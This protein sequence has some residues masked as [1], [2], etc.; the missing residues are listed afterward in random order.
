M[1]IKKVKISV[2][3]TF[4]RA[5]YETY[6]RRMID[7]FLKNWPKDVDLYVYGEDCDIVER[8]DNLKI[9]DLHQASPELVAF[10]NKWKNVPKAVGKEAIPPVIPGIK[11]QPGLGFKW[12]AVRFSHKV[13]SIFHCAK[14]CDSDILLWMDADSVCHSPINL[15]EIL[16]FCPQNIDL[17]FLGR[18]GK[19]TECGLYYMNLKSPSVQTF[20]QRFQHFY[21]EAEEGIFKLSEWHDSFVFDAVRKSMQLRELNWSAGLI[22]GEGHP[23]INS[24]WGKY[25]DHLKG[26]RKLIGKSKPG[27]LRVKRQESYWR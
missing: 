13:Y 5:G 20:L 24:A 23:L 14:V 15:D 27:D 25:L 3:T 22:R 2:V 17:A 12:D 21:D 8:A 10:K 16:R 19:Y 7:T 26:D 9:F 4:H 11:K 1:E 6:G 18:E